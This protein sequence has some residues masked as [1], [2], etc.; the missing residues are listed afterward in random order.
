MTI[1]I[2]PSILAANMAKLGEECQEVLDA[3][4][5]WIHFDVMDNHYV[6]NL[7]LGPCVCEALINYGIKAP[8]DV[9]IM[10][11]PVD[12]LIND[13]A[14]AGAQH[15][16]I[17]PE[18]TPHLD[19]S[20]NLIKEHGCK[21]G[22]ALNPATPIEHIEYVSHLLDTVLV[23]TVNPGFGGQKILLHLIEK[24]KRIRQRWPHLNTQVD[25]GVS[26][27]NIK[28]LA[29]AGATNFVAGSAIFSQANREKTI[30][31]LRDAASA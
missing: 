20:L 15:I 28:Q 2:S 26:K 8:I 7:T 4:A 14:K 3:G 21:A 30:Q 12:A 22:L 31:A 25:G 16:S 18:S 17:H 19:R 11:A 1:I 13:F 29:Q 10:A 5:D 27:D 24:I 6:P 23:M 9:H